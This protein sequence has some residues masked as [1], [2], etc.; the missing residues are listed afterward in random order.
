MKNDRVYEQHKINCIL[1][2][3]CF[4]Q[5]YNV[6]LSYKIVEC[7]YILLTSINALFIWILFLGGCPLR[8]HSSEFPERSW[9]VQSKEIWRGLFFFFL[10]SVLIFFL[11][12]ST[13]I[14]YCFSSF[15]LGVR[16][17]HWKITLLQQWHVPDPR[18][19]PAV[20]QT[21]RQIL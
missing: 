9:P 12:I 21:R 17:T 4:V 19:K 15:A 16:F 7:V 13:K 6:I 5:I 20:N 8:Y 10:R 11:F 1:I 3:F 14:N 18:A 2:V